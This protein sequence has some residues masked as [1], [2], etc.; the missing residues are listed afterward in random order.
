MGWIMRIPNTSAMREQPLAG[1]ERAEFLEGFA[2]GVRNLRKHLQGGVTT[3]R[4]VGGDNDMCLVL[5]DLER[6]GGIQGPRVV[7][8]GRCITITGGHGSGMGWEADT[9]DAVRTAARAQLKLGVD[10]IKIM[11]SGGVMTALSKSGICQYS[12]AELHEAVAEAEKQGKRV[13]THAHSTQAI[14]NSVVAGIHSIEHGIYLDDECIEMMA[15]KGTYLVPT[16]NTHRYIWGHPDLGK[17]PRLYVE[18]TLPIRQSNYIGAQKALRGS[19]KIATGDDAG[20]SFVE[21][22]RISTEVENL[23]EIGM[24]PID[25]IKAATSVSSELLQID[26]LTG[27]LTAGKVADMTIVRGNPVQDLTTLRYPVVVVH[28]GKIAALDPS[29]DAPRTPETIMLTRREGWPRWWWDGVQEQTGDG[30]PQ[31][32]PTRRHA[33]AG[34]TECFPLQRKG[35]CGRHGRL[36]LSTLSPVFW[37]RVLGLAED[38]YARPKSDLIKERTKETIS[39]VRSESVYLLKPI[40]NPTSDPVCPS[41]R[42]RDAGTSRATCR[43]R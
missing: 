38:Y 4:D 5:R 43:T 7:T 40:R 26:H 1:R 13:A 22:G 17:W 37:V 33:A 9:A 36:S 42:Q 3:V 30:N 19:V 29:I 31:G 14:K 11:S 18:K 6:S 39:S 35:I 28:D 25:A 15:Q 41:G 32:R 20:L 10:L 34:S 8:S 24:K 12:V 2:T 21:H 27:T 23:Y 16:L